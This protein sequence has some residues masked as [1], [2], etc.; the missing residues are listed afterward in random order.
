MGIWQHAGMFPSL[1]K[2]LI[3]HKF[4]LPTRLRLC[5]NSGRQK[6]W[7]KQAILAWHNVGA[8][9]NGSTADFE[10]VYLGST[11]SAPAFLP[12]LERVGFRQHV[13]DL[14]LMNRTSIAASLEVV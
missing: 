3:A 9:C 5:Y 13:V 14:R 11:P 2:A 10:S 1:E 6:T 4:G 7:R 8:W 12:D